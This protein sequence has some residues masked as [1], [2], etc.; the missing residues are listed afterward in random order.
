M[1]NVAILKGTIDS[2]FYRSELKGKPVVRFSVREFHAEFDE[3]SNSFIHSS[4]NIFKIRAFGI[5]AEKII[6]R[7]KKGDLIAIQGE[8]RT[9]VVEISGEKFSTLEVVP[10]RIHPCKNANSNLAVVGL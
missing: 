5:L 1:R 2:D 3:A 8:M 10:K 4:P 6:S 9:H 7:F